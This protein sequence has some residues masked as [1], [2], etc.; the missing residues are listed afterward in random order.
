VTREVHALVVA[1]GVEGE[2]STVAT[3]GRPV[4][5]ARSDVSL[6]RDSFCLTAVADAEARYRTTSCLSSGN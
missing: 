4:A 6:Q 1:V 5:P 3:P 2:V